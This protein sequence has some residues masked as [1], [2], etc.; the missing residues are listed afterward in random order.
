MGAEMMKCEEC[1]K[2]KT[3][4]VNTICYDCYLAHNRFLAFI[5]EYEHSKRLAEEY[6][7]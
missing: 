7:I 6:R 1:G 3:I 5:A 2:N 4:F